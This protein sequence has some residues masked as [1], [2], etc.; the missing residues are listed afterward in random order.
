MGLSFIKSQGGGQRPDLLRRV[1]V[2]EHHLE[3]AARLLEA[4]LHWC[5]REHLLHHVRS[6][7]QVIDSL[8]QRDDVEHRPHAALRQLG[9]LVHRGD[10]PDAAG[11]AHDVAAACVG[12]EPGLNACDHRHRVEHFLRRRRQCSFRANLRKGSR[13]DL[14]V[15]AHL[16]RG[17]VKPECLRLPDQMLHLTVCLARR[18]RAS[19]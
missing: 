14:A 7:T 3:A 1:G 12:A 11:E 10:V 2:A 4:T 17:E 13:V 15:L 18:A 9:E 19:K 6:L 8:E 16:E 5:K